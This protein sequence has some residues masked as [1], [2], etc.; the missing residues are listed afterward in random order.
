MKR[1]HE[2]ASPFASSPAQPCISSKARWRKKAVMCRLTSV[3]LAAAARAR[4]RS[5]NFCCRVGLGDSIPQWRC[6]EGT[7]GVMTRGGGAGM[8]MKPWEH[9]S[10]R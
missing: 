8:R 7:L 3:S 6:A 9:E 2:S 4:A 10:Q 1:A 5:T